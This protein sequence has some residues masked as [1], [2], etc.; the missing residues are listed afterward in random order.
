MDRIQELE[1]LLESRMPGFWGYYE[2]KRAALKLYE[3]ELT[4]LEQE[5]VEF[6]VL[7]REEFAQ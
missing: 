3:E 7:H 2:I 5:D 6:T 4:K 1:D